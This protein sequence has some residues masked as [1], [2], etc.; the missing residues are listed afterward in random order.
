MPEVVPIMSKITE[1]KLTGPNYLNWSK[2]ICFYLRSLCIVSRLDK[3]P[4]ID[5]SKEQCLEDDAR[6]FFQIRNFIDGKMNYLE[7]VYSGKGI[8]LAYLMCVAPFTSSEKQDRSLTK[9][10]MD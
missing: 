2:T 9:I 3:D 10:F 5:D 4:P 7:F 6:L 8:F 1:D